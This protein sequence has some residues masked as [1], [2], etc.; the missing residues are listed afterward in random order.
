[1]KRG[2]N[3]FIFDTVMNTSLGPNVRFT[4]SRNKFQG[5]KYFVLKYNECSLQVS[6]EGVLLVSFFNMQFSSCSIASNSQSRS[7][8]DLCAW[9]SLGW[10]AFVSQINS[11]DDVC[12]KPTKRNECWQ[13]QNWKIS[14]HNNKTLTAGSNLDSLGFQQSL[15]YLTF[16]KIFQNSSISL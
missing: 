7:Q 8:W 3:W 14:F 2:A 9:L 4:N 1:M 13:L 5:T 16:K 12:V 10:I 6:L 11:W 15:K